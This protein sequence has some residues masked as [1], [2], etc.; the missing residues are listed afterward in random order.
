MGWALVG[1]QGLLFLAVL[2]GALATGVGPRLPRALLAG[3]L[4]V[5][6]G[7]I[8]LLAA[9]RHLGKALTPIPIPNHTGLVAHGLYRW[10]RHPI[11]TFVLVAALGAAVGAG[12]VLGYAAVAVLALFFEM[13]T[14]LE[15]GSFESELGLG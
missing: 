7:A 9:A 14:R 6:L 5:V 4:I 15:E 2:A 11:Y 8:G 1:V 3:N 13:K 10:M 12:T